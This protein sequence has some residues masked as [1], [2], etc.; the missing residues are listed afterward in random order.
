MEKFHADILQ[1][2]ENGSEERRETPYSIRLILFMKSS[3]FFYDIFPDSDLVVHNE[4]EPLVTGF[5]L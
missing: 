2:L 5:K 1:S 4:P 3:F